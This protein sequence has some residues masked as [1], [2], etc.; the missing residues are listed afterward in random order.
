MVRQVLLLVH[1]LSLCASYANVPL[2]NFTL[3]HT[4][5]ILMTPV[6]LLPLLTSLST[7]LVLLLPFLF[8][9]RPVPSIPILEDLLVTCLNTLPVRLP[10]RALRNK[11]VR[12][13]SRVAPLGRT[14]KLHLMILA[15]TVH[16]RRMVH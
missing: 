14:F 6:R 15:V 12:L 3:T 16:P 5:D 8:N 7:V 1:P 11:H 2:G 10:R 4:Q 9:S 13:I